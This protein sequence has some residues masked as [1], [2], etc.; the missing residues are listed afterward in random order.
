MHPPSHALLV[1]DVQTDF[2]PNG[3]LAV[4]HGDQIVPGINTLMDD[5]TSVI[6]TQDWHP[7]GHYSFASQ[8]ADHAPYSQINMPYG[9][10]VLWPDH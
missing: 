5:F 10:Q 4:A 8:H 2:C 6:L 1:I 9:P 3:A 7:A